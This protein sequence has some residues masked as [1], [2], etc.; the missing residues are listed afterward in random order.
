MF[1]AKGSISSGF[2]GTALGCV[3][4]TRDGSLT[5][6]Q[7]R[8]CRS[9]SQ[10]GPHFKDSMRSQSKN[11][12]MHSDFACWM[13]KCFECWNIFIRL[14]NKN[15]LFW[16]CQNRTSSLTQMGVYTFFLWNVTEIILFPGDSGFQHI[17]VFPYTSFC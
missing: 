5:E 6:H 12:W 15:I 9:S 3:A 4:Q 14:W 7:A 8:T 11:I 13:L 17:C 2:P 1:L 16:Q 10:E